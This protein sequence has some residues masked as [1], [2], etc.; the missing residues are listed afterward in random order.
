[1][2][3]CATSHHWGRIFQELGFRVA[4]IDTCPTCET[5]CWTAKND[6]NDARAICEAF[7][8]P[9]IHFVPVKSV[10]QQD[11][12]AIRSVRKRLVEHRTALANQ[13]RGLAAEYG[14]VFPLSIKALRSHLL[15]VIEDVVSRNEKHTT[16]TVL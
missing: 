13:I 2:G 12:K 8:R 5:I 11:F 6:A 10:E 1:M 15:L 3:S 7:S 4:L 14:V 9:D 16:N